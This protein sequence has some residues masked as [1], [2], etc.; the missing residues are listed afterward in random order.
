MS[1][2][3]LPSSSPSPFTSTSLP[4]LPFSLFSLFLSSAASPLHTLSPSSSASSLCCSHSHSCL[5]NLNWFR[6]WRLWRGRIWKGRRIGV[7]YA[8]SRSP[9][10]SIVHHIITLWNA[11]ANAL[12]SFS[13]K[14]CISSLKVKLKHCV[15]RMKMFALAFAAA[16]K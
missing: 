8:S 9:G 11:F 3:L 16:L 15:G 1:S 14:Y 2:S 10:Q 7:T 13:W 4:S 5:M 12:F 6:L